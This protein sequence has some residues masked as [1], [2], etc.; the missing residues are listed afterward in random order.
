MTPESKKNI[1]QEQMVL[2]YLMKHGSITP[3]EAEDYFGIMRLAAVIFKLRK[4]KY[5][6]VT[7]PETRKNRFGVNVTYA[8][9]TMEGDTQ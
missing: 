2:D 5:A 7:V 4:Q 8:R 3:K 6:I 1:V 9:Y